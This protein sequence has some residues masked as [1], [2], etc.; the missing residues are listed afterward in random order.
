MS[1]I[2]AP[3]GTFAGPESDEYAS[4]VDL[5]VVPEAHTIARTVHPERT[6]LSR[7]V[8]ADSPA[9]YHKAQGA[10][11][12]GT[13]LQTSPIEAGHSA[14]YEASHSPGDLLGVDPSQDDIGAQWL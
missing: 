4:F 9:T 8:N 14:A 10:A 13:T 7:S 5:F 3:P 12:R 11:I 6:S 2:Q 1:S